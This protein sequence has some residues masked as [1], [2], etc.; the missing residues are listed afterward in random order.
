MIPV[1]PKSSAKILFLV[2]PTVSWIA[3]LM[4]DDNLDFEPI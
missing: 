1:P 3:V 2:G 4:N